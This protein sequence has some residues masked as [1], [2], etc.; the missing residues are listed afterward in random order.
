MSDIQKLAA[1]FRKVKMLRLVQLCLCIAA[2][3]LGA[4]GAT[5]TLGFVLGGI[6]VCI[7]LFYSRGITREYCWQVTAANICYGICGGYHNV[8]TKQ[9]GLLSEETFDAWKLLPRNTDNSGNILSL[10]GFSCTVKEK[11]LNCAETTIHYCVEGNKGKKSYN[12]LSGTSLWCEGGGQ[13]DWLLLHR[14]W[15]H[16][17]A[18]EK[19]LE[20]HGYKMV[21]TGEK[22]GEDF[23]LFSCEENAVLTRELEQN[24]EATIEGAK[25]LGALRLSEAYNAV[26]LLNRFYSPKVH[27]VSMP[28]PD[29]LSKNTL[30]ERDVLFRILCK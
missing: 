11:T 3:V 20:L 8:Q 9:K 2:V 13:G 28:T 17:A 4:I 1:L 21:A 19:F 5:R 6:V 29:E 23:M 30:P 24:L 14:D 12:F 16:P 10:N 22:L 25:T 27:I 18:L 26:F 15:I 7:Y